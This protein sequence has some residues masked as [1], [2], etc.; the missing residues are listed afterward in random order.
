MELDVNQI[1]DSEGKNLPELINDSKWSD[2]KDTNINKERRRQKNKY[3]FKVSG[4]LKINSKRK[5]YQI[6]SDIQK[7]FIKYLVR[8][9]IYSY[10]SLSK[11]FEIPKST[12]RSWIFDNQHDKK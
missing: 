3:F 7:N 10:T 6:C 1:K 4:K 2:K 11:L 5:D 9:K 12:L 8:E